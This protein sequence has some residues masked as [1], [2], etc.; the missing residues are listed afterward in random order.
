MLM[1]VSIHVSRG[2]AEIEGNGRK[3]ETCL[4]CAVTVNAHGVLSI[5]FL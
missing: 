5:N 4:I 3:S 1:V 2:L